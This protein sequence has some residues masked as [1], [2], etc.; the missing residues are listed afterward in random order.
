MKK[1]QLILKK[2]KKE[3]QN[4][5]RQIQIEEMMKRFVNWT[6][7]IDFLYVQSLHGL[8]W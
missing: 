3:L 8:I 4:L 2:V 1:I 7:L 5:M 6:I